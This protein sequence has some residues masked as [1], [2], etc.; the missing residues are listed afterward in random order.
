M[1]AA[2][3]R[4]SLT[5]SLAAIIGFTLVTMSQTA[6]RAYVPSVP[7]APAA[8]LWAGKGQLIA[9]SSYYYA[10]YKLPAKKAEPVVGP[11]FRPP[12]LECPETGRTLCESVD[13]YPS[14]TVLDIVTTTKSN[15]FNFS[16]LFADE[17]EFDQEPVFPEPTPAPSYGKTSGSGYVV[18][19]TATQYDLEPVKGVPAGPEY[20]YYGHEVDSYDTGYGNAHQ[21]QYPGAQSSRQLQ[22]PHPGPAHQVPLPVQYPGN[23]RQSRSY[24]FNNNLNQGYP[25]YQQQEQGGGYFG[26]N[27][28]GNQ[29]NQQV[30][31]PKHQGDPAYLAPAPEPAGV[32]LGPG[33]QAVPGNNYR[34]HYQQ[35]ANRALDYGPERATLVEAP[36]S[37][38]RPYYHHQGEPDVRHKR[39]K[40]QADGENEEAVEVCRV[41][42]QFVSPRAALND[43]SQW[44]Y[45]VNVPERDPRLRQT[46]KVDICAQPDEPCSNQL[47]LPFGFKSRCKQKYVK[48]KLLALNDDGQGTSTDHFFVPSCCVCEIV[49]A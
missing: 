31:Q 9:Q 18:Y 17:E 16:S 4:P 1:C 21:G 12:P 14:D 6:G 3:K 34:N 32:S 46:V 48:K 27:K 20:P 30:N 38:W 25:T 40:R 8:H 5:T 7:L 24:K 41:N 44:K 37:I 23:V 43:K 19:Q 10:D 13:K 11:K 22:Q 26:N 42:Q 35:Q 28:P 15:K 47:S 29:H 49:R 33:R 36:Q 45:I 39:H 2:I